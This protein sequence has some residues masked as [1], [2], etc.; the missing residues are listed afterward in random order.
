[1]ATFHFFW[2]RKNVLRKCHIFS[3][4]KLNFFKLFDWK[5]VLKV[6][7]A[8]PRSWGCKKVLGIDPTYSNWAQRL[9]SAS[10]IDFRPVSGRKSAILL[11]P[12]WLRENSPE[13]LFAVPK[14]GNRRIH[15]NPS[16]ITVVCDYLTYKHVWDDFLKKWKNA[17]F[18]HNLL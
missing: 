2:L 6:I 9:P 17:L 12:E 4:K 5:I 13:D 3:R 18:E 11:M 16:Q 10:V 1:M 15:P 7:S 8:N 14:L